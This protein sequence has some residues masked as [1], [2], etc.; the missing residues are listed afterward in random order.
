MGVSGYLFLIISNDQLIPQNDLLPPID[1]SLFKDTN[2]TRLELDS[3]ISALEAAK[4]QVEE[5]ASSLKIT[6][7][8]DCKTACDL[9]LRRGKLEASG[10]MGKKSGRPLTN[11]VQYLKIFKLFDEL[12]PNIV[13]MKGHQSKQKRN[14]TERV[15]SFVDQATRQKL[16]ELHS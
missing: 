9:P 6:V 11:K 5:Q 12:N 7:Y 3:I 16:R 2:C 4:K 10:F 14:P 8:T 15:F 1:F 13:W